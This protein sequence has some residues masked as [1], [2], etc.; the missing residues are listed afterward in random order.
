[1][2]TLAAH[3]KSDWEQKGR[4][5]GQLKLLALE[6][7]GVVD[8]EEVAVEDGL[9]Q[10]GNDGDPVGLVV[11]LGK[12]AVNPV[13]NVKSAIAA[14]GKEVVSGDG[15]GLAGAL[16]HE[17]LGQDGDG[18][19]P[20]GKGPEYLQQGVAD[21]EDDGHDGGTT[22]EVLD[23]KCV[24]V[25]VVGG[26]VRVG[27]EVDDV[28]LGADEEDLE[29]KVVQA[30]GEE[31]ICGNESMASLTGLEKQEETYRGISSRIP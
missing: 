18:F 28:A 26:L 24:D 11:G 4:L 21:R 8:V 22:E 6:N 10:A 30:I 2:S 14:E 15:L 16:Q 27:H 29:D 7:L 3:P 9:D 1:M 19:E 5:D 17:E 20:D 31:E 13:G 25:G 12:V 23:A